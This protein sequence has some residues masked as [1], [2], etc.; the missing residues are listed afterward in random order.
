[1]APDGEDFSISRAGE[2]ARDADGI[3]DGAAF[4]DADEIRMRTGGAE[5]GIVGGGDD[6]TLGE[7]FVESLNGTEENAG[8]R[9]S[10][11]GDD[12][13]GGVGP[14]DDGASAGWRLAGGNDDDAG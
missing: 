3:E 14:R 7:E 13:S 10:A 6:E 5:A 11:L 2:L 4:A 12:A 9:W 1:M 8:E